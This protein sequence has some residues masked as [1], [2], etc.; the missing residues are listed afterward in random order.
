LRQCYERLNTGGYIAL[1]DISRNRTSKDLRLWL[2]CALLGVPRENLWSREYY[3]QELERIGFVD[4]EARDV[5]NM[6]FPGLRGYLKSRKGIW[7]LLEKLGIGM[8]VECG[9]EYAIIS[10]KKP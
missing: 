10:A 2:V 5:S 4:C 6:V 7:S 3:V 1:A 8:F 9:G